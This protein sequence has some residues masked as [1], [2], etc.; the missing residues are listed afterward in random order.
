VRPGN[1][2]MARVFDIVNQITVRMMGVNIN[3][4]TI[5]NIE[6]AGLK[7]VSEQGFFSDIFKLITAKP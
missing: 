4:N 7:I 2:I 6:M 5:G 3:R 1:R